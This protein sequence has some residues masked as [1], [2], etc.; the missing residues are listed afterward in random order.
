M[1]KLNYLERLENNNNHIGYILSLEIPGFIKDRWGQKLCPTH[2]FLLDLEFDIRSVLNPYANNGTD[3]TNKKV[4]S[5]PLFKKPFQ[6]IFSDKSINFLE[7]YSEYYADE[8]YQYNIGDTKDYEYH[9]ESVK[10]IFKS[11]ANTF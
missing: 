5:I 10:E 2:W 1:Y 8:W 7:D 11:V 3:Y 4:D 6:N 9:D